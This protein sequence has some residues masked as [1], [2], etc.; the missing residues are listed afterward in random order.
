MASRKPF[1]SSRARH[2]SWLLL[3]LLSLPGVLLADAFDDGKESYKAGDYSGAL[4]LFQQDVRDNPKHA[5]GWYNLGLTY[6]K[7][8]QYADAVFAFR[9]A[10]QEDPGVG[11]TT[12]A[13]FAEKL[14]A[15][16]EKA[17]IT[18][19]GDSQATPGAGRAGYDEAKARYD[20]GDYTGAAE[21]FREFLQ[22]HPNDARG[23]YNLGLS[24]AK[25]KRYDDALQAY[26]R[27]ERADPAL[28]FTSK[29]KFAEKVDEAKR[30]A[31][32]SISAGQVAP[33]GGAA[34]GGSND[35][36]LADEEELVRRLQQENVVVDAGMSARISAE[37]EEALESFAAGGEPRLKVL[38]LAREPSEG[39][40][41][42]TRNL[43]RY[44]S[45]GDAALIVVTPGGVSAHSA[46]LSQAEMQRLTNDSARVFATSWRQGIEYLGNAIRQE[47]R[48]QNARRRNVFIG[49][50]AFVGLILWWGARRRRK[51]LERL[52]SEAKQRTA[53]LA[54]AIDEAG[55]DARL[56]KDPRVKEYYAQ[57]SQR[58]VEASAVLEKV[59]TRADARRAIAL[60]Q[61]SDRLLGY[62]QN[63]DSAPAEAHPPLAQDGGEDVAACFFC[64]QPASEGALRPTTLSVEGRNRRVL[65]CRS[66]SDEFRQ[67]R[68]PRIRVVRDGD[69]EVPWFRSSSYDARRDW[70]RSDY[71]ARDVVVYHHVLHDHDRDPG[72]SSIVYVDDDRLVHRRME[73][74]SA[75]S[76]EQQRESAAS[77][78]FSPSDS[79]ERAASSSFFH[80]DQS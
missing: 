52:L 66:C 47:V 40:G 73:A 51:E 11:F 39:A 5:N 75:A 63:P 24:Y 25:L 2:L 19:T 20:A 46:A 1:P 48:A 8:K 29:G 62:A 9:R 14:A 3:A 12:R 27:A 13:K 6:Y 32:A 79:G 69:E 34:G 22:S 16:E 42:F 26:A 4:A 49:L 80:T 53:D 65:A 54:Q 7:Q 43:H 77:T 15:A 33:G 36:L 70:S 58:F 23:W 44:L 61:E 60:A 74:A 10:K 78:R 56:S 35:G 28:S 18:S 30:K 17:G 57:A 37:D 38:V 68:T 67:G 21:G 41:A 64:S 76:L 55:I 31:G 59:T 50:A 71:D 72:H 45:L